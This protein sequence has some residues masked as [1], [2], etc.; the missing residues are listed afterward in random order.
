MS[1]TFLVSAH[2]DPVMFGRLVAR[3][4]PAR[5]IAHIDAKSD[6]APFREVA[7]PN[8]EF[9]PTRVPVHWCDWSQVTAM[10]LLVDQAAYGDPDDYV[11]WLTGQD[12]PM[13]PVA[14]LEAFLAEHPGRQYAKCFR[15]AASNRHYQRQLDQWHVFDLPAAW[16]K[17]VRDRTR[18]VLTALATPIPK[19]APAGLDV[20]Q[21]HEHWVL[22]R[23]CM[24]EAR[25]RIDE[26]TAKYLRRSWCPSEKIYQTIVAS[27][28]YAAQMAEG[29]PVPF[30]GRGLYKY[31]NLHFITPEL[32]PL[33]LADA[34]AIEASG[35]FF[36]R[37]VTTADST[38]LLD[39]VDARVS[40][41]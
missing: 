14:E 34:P 41:G 39:H 29:G 38:A 17:K 10:N 33:T 37:K 9:T 23:A 19:R 20:C 40:A 31:T 27:G 5:V 16:P 26:S 15:I 24:L 6:I 1:L 32:R 25:S 18:Q 35:M 22:T 21:G 11:V 13:R 36:G 7:T 12:Y 4:A 3:L 28:P 30:E 8:V 2:A